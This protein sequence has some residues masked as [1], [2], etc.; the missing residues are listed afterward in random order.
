MYTLVY[1]NRAEKDIKKLAP[2]IKK[3]IGQA[4]SRYKQDPLGDS[5]T[6]IDAKPDQKKWGLKFRKPLKWYVQWGDPIFIKA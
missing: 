4:L 2:E 1:T 5:E 6:L 3:R